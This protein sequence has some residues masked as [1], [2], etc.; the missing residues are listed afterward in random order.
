MR[1]RPH[2]AAATL[3][4]VALAVL[5]VGV[6]TSAAPAAAAT[7]TD[8]RIGDS[9]PVDSVNPFREQNEIAYDIT[10]MSYDLLLNYSTADGQPD[11][12]NSLAQSYTVSPDVKTW[13]FH[14]R[15]GISWSDGV[16]FTSADV[17]WTYDAVRENTTNVMNAYLANVASVSTPDAYT[18]VL[19]LSQPDVRLTTIFVPILP[20]HVFAKYPVAKL[21]KI[22][23]PLP[24]VTTAPYYI[25]SYNKDGTT[26]LAVN[27]HF[28]G[29]APAVKRILVTHYSDEDALLRD[30][31]LGALDAVIDGDGRWASEL[32][33]NTAIHQ[34][35]GA[36]PGFDEIA[37]NSC[38]KAGAGN[39]SGPGPDVHV[40]V[41]QDPAIRT[42][43]AWGINRENIAQTVYSGQNRPAYGLISP[44]YSTFFQDWST[45]P[46][47][48][49][50]FNQAKARQVLAAGGWNCSTNP[51]TKNGVKAQFTL[52]AR[53][54]DEPG[55]NAM[56]RVV[57]WA[58][59][60]GIQIR[61][62]I[63][64]EDAL[65]NLIYAP[66]P[67]STYRPD[68]DAFYW[69]WTGDPTPDFN[70][71]VLQTGSSWSDSYYSNPRFDQLSEQ[72]LRTTDHA[73]RADLL[74]QAE[75]IAMT[76]LP[77][78]PIV[79]SNSYDLTRTDTWHDFQP[80]PANASGT[81]FGTNWQQVTDLLP[82]PQPGTAV[83]SGSTTSGVP[84]P[85]TIL[86]AVAVG[87]V[88]FLAG[89]RRRGGAAVLDW[90]DE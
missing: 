55:Q 49:Y 30:I 58:G 12:D 2:R 79:Y 83:A 69:A 41:V 74:H 73:A 34:W 19:K 5:A 62:S 52:V 45:D 80:S 68:Y 8:L 89:R 26:V 25:Q 33:G 20:K 88:A 40:K 14:L 27:K 90:T 81:P 76:D 16:P 71:S 23:L 31:K 84:V 44:F 15:H 42:A 70:F 46:Q 17:Q 67:K 24:S 54:N 50:R 47:I 82:G 87:V 72:A 18:V 3:A 37:F 65:N 53:L 32:K 77:Y 60:I 63:L 85:A 13:T 38:P 7:S 66:G 21:D 78:I 4:A 35:S 22:D 75:K 57:A 51:C 28:R 29:A 61:L 9:Q 6:G 86:I 48:G 36:A 43:L 10:S 56:R 1:R 39:C 64:T 11:L 59:Q